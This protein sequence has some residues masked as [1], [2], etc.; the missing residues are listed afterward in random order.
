MTTINHLANFMTAL[1]IALL[2]YNPPKA[3]QPFWA[4]V[5]ACIAL[6]NL[7]QLVQALSK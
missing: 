7:V 1:Y 5:W 3:S 2:V 4:G 6:V